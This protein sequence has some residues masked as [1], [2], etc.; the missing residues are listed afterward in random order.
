MQAG[1]RG[2]GLRCGASPVSSPIR[3]PDL[4]GPWRA[5]GQWVDWSSDGLARCAWWSVALHRLLRLTMGCGFSTSLRE[6]AEGAFEQLRARV[7]HFRS[8]VQQVYDFLSYT[9]VSV[10]GRGRALHGVCLGWG[11]CLTD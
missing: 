10:G 11:P 5:W 9:F 1:S 4:A 8:S 3:S 7:E 2:V 6:Q